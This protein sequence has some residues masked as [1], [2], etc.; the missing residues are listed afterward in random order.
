MSKS[1]AE[2]DEIGRNAT[3]G[4]IEGPENAV[5]LTSQIE[6]DDYRVDGILPIIKISKLRWHHSA[7]V[8]IGCEWGGQEKSARVHNESDGTHISQPGQRWQS[9]VRQRCR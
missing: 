1:I 8:R 3:A 4:I 7:P 9:K 5:Y 2:T 6:R